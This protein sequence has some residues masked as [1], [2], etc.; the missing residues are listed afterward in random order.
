MRKSFLLG[1]VTLASIL[2]SHGYKTAAFVGSNMLDRRFGL[3]RGFD[4]YDSPFGGRRNRASES[5]FVARQAGRRTGVARGERLAE[6]LIAIRP[7]FLFI[8]LFDLHTPYKLS[9]PKASNEPETGRLRC[10]NRL[11]RPDPGTFS[12]DA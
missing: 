9:P 1:A 10:G 6:R 11:C 7:V 3:D 8:H 4:E 12:S 2:R 5:I